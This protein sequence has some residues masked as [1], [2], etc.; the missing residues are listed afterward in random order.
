M[1][2]SSTRM[3]IGVCAIAMFNVANAEPTGSKA[4]YEANVKR[5][6]ADYEIAKAKCDQ[7]SGNAKDICTAKAESEEET[8]KAAAE[9][10]YKP[11]VKNVVSERVTAADGDYEVAK[12]RCDERTGNEKDICRKEAEAAH[13]RVV[14]AAKADG[15]AADARIDA[16]EESRD[17]DYDAAKERCDSFAGDR[18]DACVAEAKA[19]FS[20]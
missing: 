10:N 12:Q 7:L 18:K 9:A 19:R 14:A 4:A 8:R 17:A 6:S 2:Q 5:A 11:T 15:K 16:M 20:K 3:L 1:F 13:T